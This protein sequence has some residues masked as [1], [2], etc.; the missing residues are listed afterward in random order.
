MKAIINPKYLS[1]HDFILTLPDDLGSLPDATT[2]HQ[3]RNVVKM[4][5]VGDVQL[6]VKCYGQISYANRLLY[7]KLRQS[8]SMRAYYNALRLHEF[9]INT[10][11]P[12]AS[13]DVYKYG[14]LDQSFFVSVYSDFES[15][16][17]LGESVAKVDKE[18]L[19]SLADFIIL[20]HSKGIVHNDLNIRN[21]RCKRVNGRYE[22]E[23][24]D[25]NRM[26]FHS[27]LTEWQ[28]LQDLRHLNCSS[29]PLVY[30]LEHYAQ[31]TGIDVSDFPLKG[32]VSRLLYKKRNRIKHKLKDKLKH[33]WF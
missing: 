5:S 6:V 31:A 32:I 26:T 7:G 18:L 22:F 24:I 1:L 2:L 12:V 13:V 28:R 30:M 10:P 4:L 25:N 33:D 16:V 21:I 15:L 3:G 11:E 23:L 19:D 14:V 17:M 8:K 27:R 29:L 20:V 9:G